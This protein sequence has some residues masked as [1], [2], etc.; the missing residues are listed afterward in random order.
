MGT[1][2]EQQGDIE[3]AK[4]YLEQALAIER[5]LGNPLGEAN[6]LGNLGVVAIDQADYEA[7]KTYL[8]Q[9]A[10]LYHQLG[11]TVPPAFQFALNS[12]PTP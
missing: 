11:L 2:K 5:Q 6:Q 7:A 10:H 4:G 1:L 8:E 3:A 9:S 12:L